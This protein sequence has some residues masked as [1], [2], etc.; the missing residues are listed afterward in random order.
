ML[1]DFKT[2][3]AKTNKPKALNK[4]LLKA[5][6]TYG[7]LSKEYNIILNLIWEKI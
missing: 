6:A 4:I 1:N 5:K 7:F 3:I 2:L